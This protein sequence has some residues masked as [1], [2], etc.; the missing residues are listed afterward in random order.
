M[1]FS[2]SNNT[3]HHYNDWVKINNNNFLTFNGNW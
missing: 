3:P 2:T 1:L